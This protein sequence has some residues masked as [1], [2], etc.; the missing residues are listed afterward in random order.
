MGSGQGAVVKALSSRQRIWYDKYTEEWWIFVVTRF[1]TR[2]NQANARWVSMLFH[3]EGNRYGL[4]L[5]AMGAY[6]CNQGEDQ[7]NFISRLVRAFNEHM[8]VAT[9]NCAS[10]GYDDH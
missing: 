8:I 7:W 1:P 2:D 9:L 10:D 5:W 4:S 6:K 3:W